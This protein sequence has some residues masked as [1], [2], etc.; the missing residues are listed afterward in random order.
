MDQARKLL[1]SIEPKSVVDL[2]DRAD[3]HAHLYRS[4]GCAVAKLR[5]KD[6]ADEGT[7]CLLKFA[8]KGGKA[9][10]IPVRA[11]LQ[12]YLD[13]YV[14]AGNLEGDSKDA[15]LFR[16]AAGRSAK[17]S[18]RALNGVD[19]C[20]LFKRRLRASRASS[21]PFTALGA[22]LRCD[23]LAA[24]RCRPGGCPVSP[25]PFGQPG[26]QAL[27]SAPKRVT[28]NIVERISI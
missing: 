22:V 10:S 20:R 2:R 14:L 16:T 8:E 7:Q 4:T 15:P 24:P 9:R 5:L 17:L 27:R 28:R 18:V 12:D 25:R 13:Q 19:I 21:K 6:F 11:D 1:A 23:R 26:Y 3:R